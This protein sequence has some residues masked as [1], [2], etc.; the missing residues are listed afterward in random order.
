MEENPAR[1]S[2]PNNPPSLSRKEFLAQGVSFLLGR[3]QQAIEQSTQPLAP[4]T[5][6]RFLRPPGAQAEIAFLTLCT[7]C[8]ACTAA[9]PHEALSVHYGSGAP[10][11][12]TPV[13]AHLQA[14]PC[15]LCED[16]PCITVC[17]TEALQPVENIRQIRVGVA[18]LDRLSCTAFRGSGCTTC[19]DV[20]PLK[21]EA[22]EVVEGL[23]FVIPEACTGCGVCQ[24]HCPVGNDESPAAIQVF[25][26]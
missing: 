8:D 19:Y 9:C 10:H 3:M 22:I 6:R 18:E 23:P 26:L 17:P 21:D 7:R 14:H 4:L 5:E 24:H 20:C 12:G 13:L 2:D 15:L 1:M 25:P 16:T 11:D